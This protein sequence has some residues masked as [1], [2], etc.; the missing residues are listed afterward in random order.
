MA[1]RVAL[2]FDAEHPDRPH[3]HGGTARV[4]D[5][6]RCSRRRRHVLHPGTLGP[7]RTP[8]LPGR[9]PAGGHLVGN[10][11]FYHARMPL[12]TNAG[13]AAD[14][15]AAER[16]IARV[17]GADPRPWFR[18]PFGAGAGDPRVLGVLARLGYR[19]VGWDVEGVDWA[20]RASGRGVAR[21]MRRADRRAWRWGDRAAP[22]VDDRAD[23]G[24][25][26]LIDGLRARGA[27]FVR[28][29]ALA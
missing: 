13:I 21:E 20:I 14:V 8:V 7:V 10:H 6:P 9:S 5:T 4:L 12:L 22:S 19:E 27:A 1:F 28:L 11:S 26:A 18:C 15:R 23:L 16:A 25:R 24:L 3:R 17:T 2:T 29:D